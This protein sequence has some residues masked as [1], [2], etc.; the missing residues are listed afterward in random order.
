MARLFGHVTAI[1]VSSEMI[2]RASANLRDLDNISLILGDGASLPGVG[3]NSHDFAFSYIVFQRIP[4]IEVITS[5]CRE[6]HRVLKPGSLFK[7]Q[8]QG[9][10]WDRSEPPDTWNGVSVT[11]EDARH[12]AAGTGFA[13]EQSLGGGTQYYWLWLRKP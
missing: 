3:D 11:A 9:A 13:F 8:G 6:I 2:E 4:S 12:L 1:D 7:F 5:Y 10:V